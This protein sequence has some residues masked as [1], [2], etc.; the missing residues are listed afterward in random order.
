MRRS[1]IS[2]AFSFMVTL[3]SVVAQPVVLTTLENTPLFRSAVS[4]ATNLPGPTNSIAKLQIFNVASASMQGGAVTLVNTQAWIGRYNGPGNFDDGP[5][6]LAL[7]VAGNSVVSGYSFDAHNNYDFATIKYADNGTAL[8]TN[9][10]DGPAH[11]NDFATS[12]A[13]DGAGNVYVAGNSQADGAI[14][15]AV[16]IKYVVDGAPLW[17]N[18]FNYAGTNYNGVQNLAVDAS[19]NVFLLV[20]TV[21]A[22]AGF[23]TLKYDTFGNAVWT[24]RY[25]PRADGSEFP[26]ALA[27]DDAGNVFVTGNSDGDG[28]GTD[29]LT[30]KY[31]GDGAA[32][33][34]NRYHRTFSDYARTITADKAGNVLVS[35]EVSGTITN[36]NYATIKYSGDGTPL[37]TN[38]LAG[39]NYSGGAVPMVRA[40]LAGNVFITG[41]APG[42]SGLQADVTTVKLTDA[43]LTLWTNHFSD[44]NNTGR[45][46]LVGSTCDHAGHLYFV[47]QAAPPGG[48]DSDFL[49][50]KF[51]SD[52]T[53]LWTNRLDGPGQGSD[54]GQA[55]AVNDAGD[56]FVTGFSRSVIIVAGQTP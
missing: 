45:G 23:I 49:A 52:G 31:S 17:T 7:D 24:N 25:N 36:V 6:L 22:D 26:A 50:V 20:A 3:V 2:I 47:G 44:L 16:V 30:L 1:L 14:Q 19:G 33:W 46:S 11:R 42:A 48:K 35:G 12:L 29:F 51:G 40:D 39:P 56:V 37:W 32:L 27:I 5:F 53:T 13:T 21:Y 41:G 55:I 54:Y 43:G 28:T 18:R 15:D 38:I 4:L 9:R 10:Y 34:T 8:W